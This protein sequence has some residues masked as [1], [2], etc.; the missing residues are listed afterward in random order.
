[1]IKAVYFDM[2]DTLADAHRSMEQAECDAVGVTREQWGRA[3]WEETLTFDRGIGN[4]KTVRE[5]IDR[6]CE[7][8][9]VKTT[10]AQ[11]DAAEKARC[12]RLRMAM[13][14]MDPQIVKCIR[15]LKKSGLKIGLISNADVC[16]RKYWEESPVFPFFDDAI[17]SCDVALLKPDSGIY[18]LA[19]TNLRVQPVEAVFAGDGGSSELAGAKA[20][21]MKTVCTEFL[22]VHEEKERREIHQSAD[23]VVRNF[24]EL[25][26][27]I[28]SLALCRDEPVFTHLQE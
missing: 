5:M 20:V 27:I 11:R 24:D 3:M 4:I 17:F 21:G 8:L 15:R 18:E 10:A 23:H 19:L 12:E 1:M 25:F 9:S 14:D 7:N 22:R 16:D 2:F 28:Q 26:E 6:A 13:T